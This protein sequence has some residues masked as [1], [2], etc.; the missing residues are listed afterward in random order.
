MHWDAM[1]FLVSMKSR[2]ISFDPQR[3]SPFS[4]GFDHRG[5]ISAQYSSTQL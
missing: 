1:I 5:V 4:Q 2:E 3:L